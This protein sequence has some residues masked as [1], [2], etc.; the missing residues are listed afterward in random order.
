[1]DYGLVDYIFSNALRTIYLT[2]PYYSNTGLMWVVIDSHSD[3]LLTDSQSQMTHE[4]GNLEDFNE[5]H[6]SKRYLTILANK[7]VQAVAEKNIFIQNLRKI[8]QKLRPLERRNK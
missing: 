4:I 5:K 7:S 3:D 8:G 6:K 2:F 1:M